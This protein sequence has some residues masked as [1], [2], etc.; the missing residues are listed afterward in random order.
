MEDV[1]VVGFCCFYFFV[2]CVWRMSLVFRV[3][4][5][6]FCVKGVLLEF[7]VYQV[8]GY[9]CVFCFNEIILCKFLVLREYQFYEI[10]FVEMCKFIFQYKGVVFV[11]FEEDEDRN[12]CL[13]VYLLKGDYG[14]VDIVDNLDCE[15]KSKFLRWI[16]NKKYYVL[17]IEKIFKDW[18]CQYCKEEKMKSYKLE[19]E[20]EWLK[21][22]EVLYYIVEKKG[23]ISFQFKY[24]NFWSMKCYQ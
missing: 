18:V 14:I 9:L 15:L 6:E 21:K 13:I 16:I 11:C 19:E 3:M 8:G 7:F 23:N 20:F 5:V 24:Y 4:D 1:L 22:F 12:L 17:E 10:F 2:I